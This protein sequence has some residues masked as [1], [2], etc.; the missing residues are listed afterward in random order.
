MISSITPIFVSSDLNE[1]EKF[2]KN[3]LD[4]ETDQKH[5]DYLVMLNG[6]IELHFSELAKVNKRKNNCACYLRVDSLDDLYKK[7]RELDCVH[8]NGKLADYPWGKE[9]SILDPD[10]NLIKIVEK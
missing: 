10:W 1:T 2:F 7:C 8:P 6:G 9:F 4:F 5:D 3:V